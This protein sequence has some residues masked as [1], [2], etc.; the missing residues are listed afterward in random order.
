[1]QPIKSRGDPGLLGT[2]YGIVS[3]RQLA[4]MH[5]RDPYAVMV[6]GLQQDS[7]ALLSSQQCYGAFGSIT[8]IRLLSQSSGKKGGPPYSVLIR[9]ELETSA[10][11]AIEWTNSHFA[12]QSLCAKNGYTKYCIGFL[13]G[14]ECDDAK[15][16]HI[17][18]WKPFSDVMNPEKSNRF[19]AIK[20]H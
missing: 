8:D 5:I 13:N 11:N 16:S 12:N 3:F 7:I 18:S 9:F 4:A 1:M 10:K 2:P 14:K 15:C 19:D 6:T 17:H 20:D